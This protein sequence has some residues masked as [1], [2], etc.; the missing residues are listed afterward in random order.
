[1]Q[2]TVYIVGYFQTL[3]WQWSY[4]DMRTRPTVHST[5]LNCFTCK[6]ASHFSKPIENCVHWF[7]RKCQGW[8]LLLG[9]ANVSAMQLWNSYCIW[10]LGFRITSLCTNSC[11]KT[12][13]NVIL[14]KMNVSLAALF[15]ASF[16]VCLPENKSS[17]PFLSLSGSH[18]MVW[19]GLWWWIRPTFYFTYILF[20]V[21]F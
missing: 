11:K 19:P 10:V 7:A 6:T 14:T 9:F 12:C 13:K 5:K 4:F 21:L 15:S 8:E 3:T 20:C 16:V 17:A 1:M 2:C 18:Q